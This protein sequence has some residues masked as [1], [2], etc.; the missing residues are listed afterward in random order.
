MN[1]NSSKNRFHCA[2]GDWL[3]HLP[4]PKGK[5]FIVAFE[6][7]TLSVELFAPRGVDT[8]KPHSRD[9]VYMIVQGEGYFVNGPDRHRFKPGDILFVP[10]GTEHHFEAFSDDLAIWVL[11][12]GPE[13]GGAA[14]SPRSWSSQNHGSNK[15]ASQMLTRTDRPDPR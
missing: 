5:P 3:Q 6:H 14:P 13:G 12:Y 9:E 4:T 15:A 11:F 10:A 1:Q 7:G 2:L 8:Q